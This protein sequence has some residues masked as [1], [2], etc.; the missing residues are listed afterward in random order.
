MNSVL[1]NGWSIISL[2]I[3][4]GSM[5]SFSLLVRVISL[6]LCLFRVFCG[7]FCLILGF[8]CPFMCSLW[9]SLWSFW[10]SWLLFKCLSICFYVSWWLFW[11]LTVVMSSFLVVYCS[12]WFV[13]GFL[14]VILSNVSHL[15]DLCE[16]FWL[17]VLYNGNFACCHLVS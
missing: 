2:F 16:C 12:Y 13:Q 1:M 8:C 17:F 3:P 14:I 10:V 7:L 15:C 11:N 4:Q 9:V 5:V 6:S